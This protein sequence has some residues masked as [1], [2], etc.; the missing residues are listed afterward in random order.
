M[1]G[2][3]YLLANQADKG[4]EMLQRAL[5]DNP[6]D[7]EVALMLAEA[8]LQLGKLADARRLLGP[9]LGRTVDARIKEHARDLLG[10]SAR[11]ELQQQHQDDAPAERSS[12]AAEPPIASPAPQAA[13]A[14]PV[15]RET[16]PGETRSYGRFV[17]IDCQPN[18]IVLH[19]K[20][21]GDTLVLRAA[22]FDAIDFITYRTN[23]AGSISCGERRPPEDVY[24][25]WRRDAAAGSQGVVV[26]VELLPDGFAPAP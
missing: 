9:I 22:R 21:A 5:D 24:V 2:Y 19:V 12:S 7:S 25:T 15:L 16:Q 4:R 18:R 10:Y 8:E 6:A 11:L 1:L 17:E 20:I 13:R 3:G 23:T 14:R 26:A